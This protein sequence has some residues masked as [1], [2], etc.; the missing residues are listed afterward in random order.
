MST[1]QPETNCKYDSLDTDS[2]KHATLSI[3]FLILRLGYK[4][5]NLHLRQKD[6][7]LL[8]LVSSG[9]ARIGGDLIFNQILTSPMRWGMIIL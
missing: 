4:V 6:P 9:I 2:Y 8:T 7:P 5:M 1:F 3:F